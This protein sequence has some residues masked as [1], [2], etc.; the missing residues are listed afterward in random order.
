MDHAAET[1]RSGPWWPWA[2]VGLAA[3]LLYFTRLGAHD[4]WEPDEPNFALTSREMMERSQ[5]VLPTLNGTPEGEK[6]PMFYWAIIAA[7]R[8]V[9]GEVSELTTRI[10]SA[11]GMLVTVL[12]VGLAGASVFG[13]RAGLLA[14]IVM[15]TTHLGVWEARTGQVDA[16]NCAFIT[17]AFT[18]FLRAS[19]ADP[20]LPASLAAAY[21]FAGLAVLTKGQPGFLLPVATLF[22]HGWIMRR[23]RPIARMGL[24]VGVPV[25]AAFGLVWFLPLLKLASAD[26]LSTILYR[27]TVVRYFNPWH[28]HQPFWYYLT[29][30]PLEFLPWTIVLPGALLFAWREGWKKRDPA[31][32]YAMLWAAVVFLYFSVSPGKRSIYVLPMFPALALLVGRF[33]DSALTPGSPWAIWVRGPV[34]AWA[35]VLALVGLGAPVVIQQ[36]YPPMAWPAAGLTPLLLLGVIVIVN[37]L[38]EST[39]LAA[40]GALAAVTFAF[41]FYLH[42][43]VLTAFNPYNSA[44]EFCSR[45][46]SLLEPGEK[47]VSYRFF[48]GAYG[49]YTRRQFAVPETPDALA[50]LLRADPDLVVMAHKEHLS[51]LAQD[52]RFGLELVDDRKIGTRQVALVRVR[53]GKRA[54]TGERGLTR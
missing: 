10:P 14:A 49:F 4:L 41:N 48:R 50:E 6:P 51:E 24:H 21:G 39:L 38:R 15:A 47:P 1:R 9:G 33:L 23:A 42:T 31:I 54:L 34:W 16:L 43:V 8:L 5:Y 17:L 35:G 18:W 40:T 3:A 11:A 26:F 27:Q 7:T 45:I 20:P 44:R 52:G 12:A 13:L 19:M 53:S 32:V 28:H 37:R 30:L 22:L 29:T 2:L 25:V 46:V 36:K